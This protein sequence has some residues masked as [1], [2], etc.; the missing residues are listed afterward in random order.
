M[1][2]PF[3]DSQF[4]V[5]HENKFKMQNTKDLKVEESK[6]DEMGPAGIQGNLDLIMASID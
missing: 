3:K 4:A 5:K 1:V 6:D 2:N